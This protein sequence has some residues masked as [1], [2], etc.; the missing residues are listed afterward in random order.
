MRNVQQIL[1]DR[2]LA[3]Q[4]PSPEAIERENILAEIPEEFRDCVS[5]FSQSCEHGEH[6]L[7]N[8]SDLAQMLKEPIKRYTARIICE[9]QPRG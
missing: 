3:R 4:K 2:E 6:D 8:L 1:A 9:H 5:I 7:D